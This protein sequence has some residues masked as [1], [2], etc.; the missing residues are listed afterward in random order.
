MKK[1]YL[2]FGL[3]F[4]ACLLAAC[5]GTTVEEVR[6]EPAPESELVATTCRVV[7]NDGG[8]LLVADWEGG[9]SIYTLTAET[10]AR[11]GALVDI[12]FD[13]SVMESWPARFSGV[14]DVTVREDGFDDRCALYLRVL[15]DLWTVDSGLNE[16]GVE[17]IGVDLSKTSLSEA[18]KEAV[19]WAFAAGHGAE[20]ITGTLDELA[21]QGWITAEPI[22]GSDSAVF[23]HWENGCF[24]AIEEQPM[25]GVYSLT[26]VTFDAW[27]WRSSLGAYFFSDCTALQT[28]LGEWS[29]YQVGSE[30]IS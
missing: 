11:P 13:G 18:E 6:P 9:N 21:D 27:K 19:T 4:T 29:D 22:D 5:G 28:A 12:T 26:P 17:V 8:T 7:T 25:E 16:S 24:F 30:M 14:T 3:Y 1:W 10:D 23:R 2:F 15:E 20:P